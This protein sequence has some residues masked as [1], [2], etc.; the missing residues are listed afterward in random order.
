VVSNARTASWQDVTNTPT[1]VMSL[2]SAG[3]TS[4]PDHLASGLSAG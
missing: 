3:S 1:V 2:S 4:G